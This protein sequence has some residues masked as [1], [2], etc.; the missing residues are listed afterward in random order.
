MESEEPVIHCCTLNI[1]LEFTVVIKSFSESL[2]NIVYIKINFN[3]PPG[4]VISF[5]DRVGQT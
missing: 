1:L 3:V 2:T 4:L 5:K